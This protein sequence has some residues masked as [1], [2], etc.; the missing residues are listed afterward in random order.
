LNKSGKH[1]T[2]SDGKAE[3]AKKQQ[4]R[5]DKQKQKK[6]TR[7]NVEE[8]IEEDESLSEVVDVTAQGELD[9]IYQD[10]TGQVTEEKLKDYCSQDDLTENEESDCAV[11]DSNRDQ[12]N[13]AE[14]NYR[15]AFL[16]QGIESWV[17]TYVNPTG[18]CD[19][20][21]KKWDDR[22]RKIRRRVQNIR[23]Q[24]PANNKQLNM[25]I[26]KPVNL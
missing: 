26:T 24:Y 3:R 20:K 12:R 16:C 9:S 23:R 2:R 10:L 4:A 18:T 22:L 5:K 1:R 25:E 6:R 13:K 17:H 11:R 15:I 21:V 8:E 7:R 19:D 14:I